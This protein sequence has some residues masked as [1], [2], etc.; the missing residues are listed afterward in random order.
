M[1]SSRKECEG[2]YILHWPFHQLAIP[3]KI[4]S[5][6][7]RLLSTVALLTGE[8]I[9]WLTCVKFS[10]KK[11]C[12]RFTAWPD[13]ALQRVAEKFIRA[14]NLSLS[15]DPISVQDNVSVETVEQAVE[16]EVVE[17]PLSLVEKSII[18]VVMFFNVSVEEAS[19]R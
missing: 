12:Q 9:D 11:S 7:I 5:E 17:S 4:D 15:P 3:L 1:V 13:D 10:T 14:M 8:K 2:R 6:S 18:E 16:V 19:A